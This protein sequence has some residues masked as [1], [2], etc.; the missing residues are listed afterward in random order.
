MASS[1]KRPRARRRVG[2]SKM[3]IMLKVV[4]L[5]MAMCAAASAQNPVIKLQIPDQDLSNNPL[6]TPRP[7]PTPRVP[8]LTR[9]GVA[10]GALPLS[11]NEAIRL[12]L[13]NNNDIE[14]S[15]DYFRIAETSYRSLQ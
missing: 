15:R 3:G 14:V 1:L 2:V 5:S 8:D 12:A 4:A 9:I 10:G 7:L 6:L 13:E 11:L